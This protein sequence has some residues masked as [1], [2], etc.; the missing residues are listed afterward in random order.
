MLGLFLVDKII[1]KTLKGAQW[2]PGIKAHPKDFLFG[3]LVI[4]SFPST[5]PL[6]G[7]SV[8]SIFKCTLNC[9]LNVLTI[10]KVLMLFKREAIF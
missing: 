8:F 5:F 6:V 4:N 10:F 1:R 7:T 2:Q 9:I 3:I